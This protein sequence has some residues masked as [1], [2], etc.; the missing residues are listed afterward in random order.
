MS[1]ATEEKVHQDLPGAGHHVLA[2]S[3]W[4]YRPALDGVRTIAVYLVVA[5]HTAAPGFAGGFVGV[6]LFFVLSGFLVTSILLREVAGTG[7]IRFS[8]FYA[9]RVRRLLPAAVSVVTLTALAYV[10]TVSVTQRLEFAGDARSALL[11]FANWH[12]I[13]QAQDY[14][15]GGAEGSPFL[16]FWSLSIEEQF[17]LVFPMA[18]T[19]IAA[20]ARRWGRVAVPVCLGA[21]MLASMASQLYWSGADQVHAYYGTDA[22]LYQMLAGA[23]FASVLPWLRQ[24][25]AAG[26]VA[27]LGPV[28][29]VIFG[30]VASSALAWSS[31]WRGMAACALAIAVIGSLEFIPEGGLGRVLST[32]PMVYLGRISYGTYLWHWPIILM[33]RD[34]TGLSVWPLTAVA[35]VLSTAVAALS[36]KILEMPIRRSQRFDRLHRP[37]IVVGLSVSVLAALIVPRALES[38]RRPMIGQRVE[39]DDLGLG[40]VPTDIDWKGV[41]SDF[42]DVPDCTPDDPDGCRVVTG[43]GP[44]VLLIGDSHSRTLVPVLTGLAEEHGFSLS[45]DELGACGWFQ[46]VVPA[47]YPVTRQE[48]CEAQRDEFYSSAISK[49][50]PDVVIVY[51]RMREPD[52]YGTEP[53]APEGI[54]TPPVGQVTDSEIAALDVEERLPALTVDSARALTA[55]GRKLIIVETTPIGDPFNPVDCLSGAELISSCTFEVPEDLNAMNQSARQVA[56][57]NDDVATVDLEPMIC[58]QAPLCIPILDDLVVWRDSNH[59]TL[60]FW[61]AHRDELYDQ[62]LAAGLPKAG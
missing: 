10:L 41:G 49:L 45:I 13:G 59:V 28:A 33:L 36:A 35:V 58:P 60:E 12:F 11:Y 50:D 48:R 7:K 38:P 40:K 57:D 4:G 5:F 15:A 18:L 3:S 27:P 54:E 17:Y 62:F 1:S 14:F 16:H 55:D 39:S 44:H 23:L 51:Q 24:R 43:G 56:N 29:L 46:G 6:D 19:G 37:V 42:A 34:H 21:L 52:Y 32:S 8:R 47:N 53:N 26:W 31:T 2:D 22:R 25:K 30:L 9:R 61:E 20:V